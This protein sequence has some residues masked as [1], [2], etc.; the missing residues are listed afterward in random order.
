MK[1]T[2]FATLFHDRARLLELYNAMS[3]KQYEDVEQLRIVTLKNAIYMNMKN[4]VAFLI[5]MRLNLYEHQSTINPNMPYRFLQY[6]AEEYE[7]LLGNTNMYGGRLVK[8]P[9]PK[10]VVFYNGRKEMPERDILRLSDAF[11]VPDENPA[12]ELVVEVLNINKGFN[13]SLKEHCESLKG[14]AEF[15]ARIRKIQ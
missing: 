7:K 14:Y 13:D 8:V 2:V 12:L 6:V 15:V 11:E 4:D 3:G 10:F 5:D 1:S 9:T